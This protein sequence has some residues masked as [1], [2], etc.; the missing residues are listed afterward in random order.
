M[1]A[2]SPGETIRSLA[3]VFDEGT[4]TANPLPAGCTQEALTPGGFVYLDNITVTT[5]DG[6]HTWTS[7]SDNANGQTIWQ[8]PTGQSYVSSLIDAPVSTLFP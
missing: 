2:F 8:D 1:P 3:I 6:S 4:D 5:T 7:A